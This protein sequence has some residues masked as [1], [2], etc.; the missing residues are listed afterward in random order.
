VIQIA[1]ILLM[2]VS[3]YKK[4]RRVCFVNSIPKSPAGKILRRELVDYALSSGSSKLW[5]WKEKHVKQH[6]TYLLLQIL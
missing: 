4:I 1:N 5:S 6:L 2:Q 3:P